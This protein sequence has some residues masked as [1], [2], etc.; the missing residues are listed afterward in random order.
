MGSRDETLH[1]L[2]Q[3]PSMESGMASVSSQ[4]YDAVAVHYEKGG[5][6]TEVVSPADTPRYQA[7]YLVG[8]SIKS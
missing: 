5:F 6:V 7:H 1:Y 3:M 8:R 4:L 2:E